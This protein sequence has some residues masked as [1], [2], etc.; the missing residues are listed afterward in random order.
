M[1]YYDV[2]GS[3]PPRGDC[4]CLLSLAY[5]L[6][7]THT[8]CLVAA[9]EH[10]ESETLETSYVDRPHGRF[11][12]CIISRV[13]TTLAP[14]QRN[15]QVTRR[16]HPCWKINAGVILKNL[17]SIERCNFVVYALWVNT[18]TTEPLKVISTSDV[19]CVCYGAYLEGNEIENDLADPR[20]CRRVVFS[21]VLA[22]FH[23]ET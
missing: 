15:G 17:L 3:C 21:A 18:M 16:F 14:G 8:I 1:S 5:I 13:T 10:E 4:T 6:A 20:L 9:L 7:Y 19:L 2:L 11:S 22:R 23:C 12:G